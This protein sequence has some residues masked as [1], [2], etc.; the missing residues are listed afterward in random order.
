MLKFTLRVEYAIKALVRLGLSE[1]PMSVPQIS[2]T[3]NIP[4]TFLE[5]I[6][7]K[8]RRAGLVNS[9]RGKRGGYT[10]AL[11][12]DRITVLDV[13]EA[14]EGKYGLAK[15]LVPGG[16]EGCSVP[17]TDC[18][19]R[20]VWSRL[21]YRIKDILSEITIETIIREANLRETL[22][23]RAKVSSESVSPS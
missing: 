8:L 16:E 15:C 7:V 6:F 13:I 2:N 12:P 3:E 10:L 14:V 19:L 17:I 22:R 4:A 11:P 20:S 18:I 1:E 23:E 5:Q 21:Q 9:I